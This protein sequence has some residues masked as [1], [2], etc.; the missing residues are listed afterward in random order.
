MRLRRA[1]LAALAPLL[2]AVPAAAQTWN[3]PALSPVAP[4]WREPVTVTVTGTLQGDCSVRLET[5]V[6]IKLSDAH[7]RI[8][9]PATVTCPPVFPPPQPPRPFVL[10][11]DLGPFDMGS[12][13]LQLVYGGQP[14][15]ELAFEVY[16]VGTTVIELPALSTAGHPGSL[17]LTDVGVTASQAAPVTVT[18]NVIIIPLPSLLPAIP[19]TKLFSFTQPLPPLVAGHY[20]VRVLTAP[21]VVF[22]LGQPRLVRASLHVLREGG[23]VPDGQTLCLHDGRFRLT[24]TWRD[25]IGRTG[26]AHAVPLADNDGSGLLW[27]FGPDN[28][29]LTVKV[30]DGCTISGRWWTFVSSSS[31]VEYT[32]TVTDT[33]TGRTRS[34]GND[35]GQVPRLIADTD[36]FPCP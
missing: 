13:T 29:E 14:V 12:Y 24:A 36:A 9:L 30:L 26:A 7:F 21:L 5:P 32:L 28:A 25:F 23:C 11:A 16:D 31:T 18:G 19:P 27:F 35:L 15:H 20:E 22:P 34:Y 10:T 2:F 3:L 4:T 33:A 17:V 6:T 8:E 1:L